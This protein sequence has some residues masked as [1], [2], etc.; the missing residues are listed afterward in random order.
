MSIKETI[1]AIKKMPEH[2]M[3]YLV[4]D[5]PPAH[6]V[7]V[8]IQSADLRELAES[9]EDLR[10]AA[11]GVIVAFSPQLIAGDPALKALET[12]FWK[13]HSLQIPAKLIDLLPT[14]VVAT[15]PNGEVVDIER[16]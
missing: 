11:F 4:L 1:E 3:V 16:P 15:F 2:K 5:T 13:S 8:H 7:R 10:N 12:A 6:T 9:L 14:G